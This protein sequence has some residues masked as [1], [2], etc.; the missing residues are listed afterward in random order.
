MEVEGL[1]VEGMGPDETLMGPQ[2]G[3]S[4]LALSPVA[5]TFSTLV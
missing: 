3:D 2:S 1:R 5:S 4:H